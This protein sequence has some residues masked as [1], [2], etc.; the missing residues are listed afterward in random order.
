MVSTL[1][2]MS[3]ML[4]SV[5]ES[6]SERANTVRKQIVRT[7]NF[8]LLQ[9]TPVDTGQAVSNWQ[10]T[11]DEIPEGT[12]P[13]FVLSRE[14]Y[15]QQRK[16]EKSWVHRV[17]SEYTRQQNLAPAMQ[18]ANATI[19]AAKPDETIIITNNL[20]YIQALDEGHSSQAQNFVERAILLGQDVVTRARIVD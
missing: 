2:E 9:T 3:K 16:G 1:A 6:L 10:V 19:D 7:V 5:A 14:G 4:R 17:D 18:L 15:M 8:D 11:V 20:P 12:R 13:P